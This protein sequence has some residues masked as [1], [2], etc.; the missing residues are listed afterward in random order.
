MRPQPRR[1]PG[2]RHRVPLIAVAACIQ[3]KPRRRQ[4][5]RRDRHHL[6]FAVGMVKLAIRKEAP[7]IVRPLG[8]HQI[9]V[10]RIGKDAQ[11]QIAREMRGGGIQRDVFRKDVLR[12]GISKGFAKPH[13]RGHIADNLPIG[14][15][16][17]RCRQKGALARDPALRVCDSAVLFAPPR[18]GQ[19]NRRQIVCVGLFHDV[20]GHNKGHIC[21]GR[22]DAP[23]IG[24]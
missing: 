2:A 13:P 4:H 7:V 14:P 20:G 6:R 23:R 24:Q 19:A 8:W 17:A 15:G 11:V 21:D 3:L 16:H 12:C 10:V 1:F 22:R 18:R 9:G 5:R